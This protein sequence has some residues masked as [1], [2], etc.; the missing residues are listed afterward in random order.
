MKKLTVTTL[1]TMAFALGAFAQGSLD[2]VQSVFSSLGI[3]TGL[4]QLT[5]SSGAYFTGNVDLE[6]LYSATATAGTIT[7]L[8]ALDGTASGGTALS[9]AENTDGF[10]VVSATTV[11]GATPGFIGGSTVAISGGDLTGADPNEVGLLTV[12]TGG[13]GVLA[14]YGIV[15]G[16]AFNNDSGLIAWTQAQL[17]GNPNGTPVAGTPA[18]IDQDPSG[19]NLDLVSSVPEPATLAFAGLGGL[20]ML[21]IRRR[22]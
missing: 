20:S 10:S 13:S 7:A 11:T 4:N 15:V 3:T 21:L 9:V 8:N 18:H 19:E 1:A 16:G 14:L 2:N 6:I 22:K 5:S 12:P 17:G